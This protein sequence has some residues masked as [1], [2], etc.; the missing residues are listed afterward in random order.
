MN[1]RG[2]VAAVF[3][4]CCCCFLFF[5]FSW[6]AGEAKRNVSAAPLS[7]PAVATGNQLVWS[8]PGPRSH[9]LWQAVLLKHDR[10]GFFFFFPFQDFVVG[11]L[12]APPRAT[13]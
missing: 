4:F 6:F 10:G 13:R 8:V 3:F 7:L 11:I 9:E 5:F 12:D 1:G 2:G